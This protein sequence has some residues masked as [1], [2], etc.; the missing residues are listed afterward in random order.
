MHTFKSFRNFMIEA[1]IEADIDDDYMN[2][3]AETIILEAKSKSQY[4][5]AVQSAARAS[6]PHRGGG[7]NLDQLIKAAE[8]EH[9]SDFANQLRAI[10]DSEVYGSRTHSK[11]RTKPGQVEKDYGAGISRDPLADPDRKGKITKSGKLDK[12]QARTKKKSFNRARFSKKNL[13]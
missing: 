7:E 5:K 12:T 9:G 2:I 13:P 10:P 3:L 11:G 4:A 1:T 8:K 6:S